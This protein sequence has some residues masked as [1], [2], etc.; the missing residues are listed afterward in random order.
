MVGGKYAN[1]ASRSAF[2][3]IF[4]YSSNIYHVSSLKQ[5][6]SGCWRYRSEHEERPFIEFTSFWNGGDRQYASKQMRSFQLWPGAGK[7]TPRD[8]DSDVREGEATLNSE[9]IR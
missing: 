6:C 9:A 2:F 8:G 3:S 7:I 4:L 1:P 5:P